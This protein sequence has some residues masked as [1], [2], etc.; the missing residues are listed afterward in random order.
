MTNVET[1]EER[2][3]DIKDI[4]NENELESDNNF[5]IMKGI[6]EI[7]EI[8]NIKEIILRITIKIKQ[9]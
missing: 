1:D 5:L 4:I 3:L 2:V 6:K 7:I 9:Y 8:L